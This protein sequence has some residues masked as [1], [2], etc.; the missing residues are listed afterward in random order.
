MAQ[1]REMRLGL[2]ELQMRQDARTRNAQVDRLRDVVDRAELQPMRLAFLVADPCYEDDGN[3]A[4]GL[5]FLEPPADFVAI[6]PRHHHIEENQVRR[7]V[8]RCNGERAFAVGCD[9]DAE[10]VAETVDQQLQIDRLIVRDQQQRPP[11]LR[12]G[13]DLCALTAPAG[14]AAGAATYR[15]IAWTASE[16]AS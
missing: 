5:L 10:V 13:H 4:C 7:L 1:L 11:R 3:V 15:R 9:S 2:P 12:I 14:F 6:Y 8:V 16:S